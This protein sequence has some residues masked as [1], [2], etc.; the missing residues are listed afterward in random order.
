MS[1]FGTLAVDRAMNPTVALGARVL[2]P[3]R[4]VQKVRNWYNLGEYF[5]KQPHQKPQLIGFLCSLPRIKELA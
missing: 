2:S 5:L 1:L 4:E 3:H